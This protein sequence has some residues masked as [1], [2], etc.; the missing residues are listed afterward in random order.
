VKCKTIQIK[1]VLLA[2]IHMCIK[3]KLFWLTTILVLSLSSCV[4]PK[5]ISEESDEANQLKLKYAEGF[6]AIS[7]KDHI[8]LTVNKPYQNAQQTLNYLL[9]KKGAEIPLHSEDTQVIFIPINRIVCTSTTHIPLLDYLNESESLVGFPTTDYISSQKTR[10]LIDL[11][12]VIDLGADHSLNLELLLSVS[13]ELVMT[14][15]I[16]SDLGHLRKIKESGIPV[17]IN[18]EY[19]EKH[20]LG[21]AEWIKFMSLFYG[22]E[23]LADSVFNEIESA[24]LETQHRVVNIQDM[25]TVMSGV[26]YGDSWF[27]PGGDNYAARL[28]QDAGLKYLWD[29]EGSSGFVPLSFESVYSTAADADYWIGVASFSSLSE[30]GDADKRYKWFSAYKNGQ[31][32]NYDARIGAKG[33]NEYLELGY[34]RPDLILKDLVKITRPELMPTH[35]LFF[36]R[37]L[38]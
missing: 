23:E 4:D 11:D 25:P 38:E 14:Y 19:L 33:G 34:L 10:S 18:A 1:N 27:L 3:M 31:L 17:V 29:N 6:S 26:L 22:K 8:W 32:Y 13:P 30:L 35:E 15:S 9:V 28:F 37:Q 5:K 24:Y 20:P 21:R 2:V 36:F 16:N 12:K 7:E